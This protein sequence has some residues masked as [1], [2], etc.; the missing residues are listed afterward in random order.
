MKIA[1]WKA[2]LVAA[3]SLM[4]MSALSAPALAEGAW[5]PFTANIS[6]TNDYRFRGISQSD[7]DAAVQGG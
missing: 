7:N 3:A 6:L 2:G 5:G 4:S 1:G